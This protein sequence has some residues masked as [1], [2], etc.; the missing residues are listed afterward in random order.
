[1]RSVTFREVL[2]AVARKAGFSPESGNF[3]TNQAIAIGEYINQWVGRVYSASDWPEWTKVL[4][5]TPDA[6]THIVPYDVTVATTSINPV[7]N[8]IGRVIAVYL[9]DPKTTNAPVGTDFSL[10]EEGIHCG[11]DHGLNVWIEYITP[12]PEFTAEVWNA[13]RTYAKDDPAY[14]SNTGECYRS[15]LNNNLGHDPSFSVSPTVP[16]LSNTLTQE[17][18]VTSPIPDQNKI[19][20][21][22]VGSIGFGYPRPSHPLPDPPPVGSVFAI[23]VMDEN[24]AILATANFTTTGPGDTLD[25][26]LVNLRNQLQ[27][28]LGGLGFTFT[29][30]IPDLTL[31]IE[32]NSNFSLANPDTSDYPKYTDTTGANPLVTIQVQGY[33]QGTV[34]GVITPQTVLITISSEQVFGGATYQ[35]TFNDSGGG[36]HI[37]Q[38][39]AAPFDDG[40][41]ILSG[42]ATAM[43]NA[44]SVDPFFESVGTSLD[45][46]AQTLEVRTVIPPVGIDVEILLTGSPWWETVPFPDALFNQVVRGAVADLLAEWGQ[47]DKSLAEEALVPQEQAQSRGDFETTPTPALTQQQKPFS[48]YRIQP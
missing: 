40:G 10:A 22:S 21:V 9:V 42:L 41:A 4:Q 45:T 36:I 43:S 8:R 5:C 37:V 20:Q 17:F 30:N 29:E 12:A 33:V 32:H 11:F 47:T 38:Y 35:A 31:S 26:I 14:S 44:Q 19:M 27:A 3:L 25:I 18:S 1:M 24:Y 6:L 16:H 34:G 48:R 13:N 15:R 7:V 23:P 46:T 39:T 28:A 2:W